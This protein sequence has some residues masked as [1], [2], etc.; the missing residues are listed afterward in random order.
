MSAGS[1]RDPAGFVLAEFT[2]TMGRFA[3]GVT[4]VTVNDELDDV[5]S[6]VNAFSSVSAEPPMIMICMVNTSYLCEV[7]DTQGRFAVNVLSHQQRA[8][9]GRFAAEG[10]PSARLL[11]AGEPHHRGEHTGALILDGAIAAMEC[12]VVRCVPAGDHNVYLAEVTSLPPVGGLP[13]EMAPLVRYGGRY[14]GLG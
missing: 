8:I 6:T 4:V 13:A 11:V 1:P 7:I 10:R 14:R 5:G 2:E 12:S 9:A 3:T